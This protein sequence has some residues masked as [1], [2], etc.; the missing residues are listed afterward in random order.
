MH[1]IN[2]GCHSR[3]TSGRMPAYARLANI[4]CMDSVPLRQQLITVISRRGKSL[5]SLLHW[6]THMSTSISLIN[7]RLINT[8]LQ[9]TCQSADPGA[10][11]EKQPAAS[12]LPT[13]SASSRV[14]LQSDV[15]LSGPC[16]MNVRGRQRYDIVC[17]WAQVMNDWTEEYAESTKWGF[18]TNDGMQIHTSGCIKG[19]QQQQSFNS[20]GL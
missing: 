18:N 12:G 6:S 17:T 16:I 7:S 5:I 4:W 1:L 19:S 9:A 10:L 8:H 20:T 2:D 11:L 13:H 3:Y 14:Y 15:H